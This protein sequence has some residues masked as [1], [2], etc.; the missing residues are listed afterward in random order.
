ME[1][2]AAAEAAEIAGAVVIVFV[3]AGAEAIVAAA[4]GAVLE[5]LAAAAVPVV[6]FAVGSDP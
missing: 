1:I 5:I 2:V 4:S 3:A 6:R